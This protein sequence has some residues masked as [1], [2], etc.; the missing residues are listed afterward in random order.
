MLHQPPWQPVRITG[1]RA[2]RKRDVATGF[3]LIEGDG[4]RDL[5]LGGQRPRGQE[6]VVSRVDDEGGYRDG[7]QP[8]LG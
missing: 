2:G 4:R 7:F 5:I 6:R 1:K 3:R 8:W